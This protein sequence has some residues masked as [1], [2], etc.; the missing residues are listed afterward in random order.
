MNVIEANTAYKIGGEQTLRFIH[1]DE[2]SE[3]MAAGTTNE[4]VLEV[5]LDRIRGQNRKVPCRENA[6]AI[7]RIEEALMWL[8]RRSEKRFQQGVNGT[9]KT[10]E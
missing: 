7:T 5:V 4:E 1:R 9:D 6:L 3:S 10:H 8:A 2:A